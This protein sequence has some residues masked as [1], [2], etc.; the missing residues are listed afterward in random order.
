MK[1][2]FGSLKPAVSCLLFDSPKLEKILLI[3][4]ENAPLFGKW[5]FPG[6]KIESNETFIDAMKRE[7][8]EET[9]YK[10]EIKPEFLYNISESQGYLIITGMAFLEN[11]EKQFTERAE[12]DLKI[13]AEFFWLNENNQQNFWN[14]PDENAI[15]NLKE[16]VKKFMFAYKK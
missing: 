9:G 15:P 13:E 16:I 7:I 5:C 10:I 12:K 11:I 1:S 3:K 2:T 8:Y 14:I 6:G 4:R